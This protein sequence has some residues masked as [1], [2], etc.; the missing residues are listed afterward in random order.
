MVSGL[1][2]QGL[3]PHFRHKDGGRGFPN[4][5][6]P[7]QPHASDFTPRGETGQTTHIPEGHWGWA[8]P[9]NLTQG[10]PL[11]VSTPPPRSESHPRLMPHL[12]PAGLRYLR[13]TLI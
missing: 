11:E 13:F 9:P 8:R 1:G 2:S 6:L 5:V 7:C 12:T 10:L 3:V 4:G